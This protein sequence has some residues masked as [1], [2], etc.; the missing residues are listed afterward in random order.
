VEGAAN[1][2]LESSSKIGKK[3]LRSAGSW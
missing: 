2:A 3:S 1:D